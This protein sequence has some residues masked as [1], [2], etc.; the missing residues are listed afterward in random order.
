MRVL[1]PVVL[2]VNVTAFCACVCA[3]EPGGHAAGGGG[4]LLPGVPR[5][6]R[7]E[8]VP[9]AGDAV[10]RA[11]AGRRSA[12]SPQQRRTHPVDAARRAGRAHSRDV[13]VA[14]ETPAVRVDTS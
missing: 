11:L 6:A 2:C 14:H 13:Q 8:P 4:R 9:R 1:A 5:H 12:A 7:E 3:G 10:G